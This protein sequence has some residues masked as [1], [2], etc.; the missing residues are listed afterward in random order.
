MRNFIRMIACA[1]IGISAVTLPAETSWASLTRPSKAQSQSKPQ[2]QTGTVRIKFVRAGL[3]VGI[4]SGSGTLVYRD[5]TY[6]LSISGVDFGSVGITSVQLEGTATNL[7]SVADIAGEYNAA[8]SGAT[9]GG[10]TREA[11]VRN[12]KGV[13]LKLRGVKSGL[14]A[15]LGLSGMSITLQ[16]TT[17]ML[18]R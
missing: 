14:H 15:S 13:V 11:T 9:I 7:R 6:Q 1:A 3:V 12:E 4:G 8:G 16:Q 5:K 2:S 18:P 10:G 17:S